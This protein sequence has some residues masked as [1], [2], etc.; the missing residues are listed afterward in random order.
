MQCYFIL[1]HLN[2]GQTLIKKMLRLL[3]HFWLKIRSN[4]DIFMLLENVPGQI[5]IN[6]VVN[7]TI[8]INVITNQCYYHPFIHPHVGWKLLFQ[9]LRIPLFHFELQ[10]HAMLKHLAQNSH[11]GLK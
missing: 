10:K 5:A 3:L 9:L 11:S 8:T 7:A 6:V 2:Y 4:C 1:N